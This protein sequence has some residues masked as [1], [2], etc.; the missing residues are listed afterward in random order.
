MATLALQK[1]NANDFFLSSVGVF[2]LFSSNSQLYQEQKDVNNM[3]ISRSS[4]SNVSAHVH[5]TAQQCT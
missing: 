3:S 5:K 2:A 4:L 1:M